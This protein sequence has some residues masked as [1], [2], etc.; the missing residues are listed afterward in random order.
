MSPASSEEW[1][2]LGN[3]QHSSCTTG[4]RCSP[5]ELEIQLETARYPQGSV[6]VLVVELPGRVSQRAGGQPQ[7][8]GDHRCVSKHCTL[9]AM[10]QTTQHTA[11]CTASSWAPMPVLQHKNGAK[12]SESGGGLEPGCG[13][14]PARLPPPKGVHLCLPKQEVQNRQRKAPEHPNPQRLR[15][16]SHLSDSPQPTPHYFSMSPTGYQRT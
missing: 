14:S 8:T 13:C 1:Q 7:D 6:P 12:Q 9:V 16:P 10:P 3:P 4:P 11:F 2:E 5:Q 15:A